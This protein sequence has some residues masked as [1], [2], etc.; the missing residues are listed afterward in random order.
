[1]RCCHGGRRCRSRGEHLARRAAESDPALGCLPKLRPSKIPWVMPSSRAS[2]PDILGAR[3]FWQEPP[4]RVS[5]LRIHNCGAESLGR[6]FPFASVAG[7]EPELG[8][9][10]PPRQLTPAP[11][12][13]QRWKGTPA[14]PR[15]SRGLPG[16]SIQP[17]TLPTGV[18]ASPAAGTSANAGAAQHMCLRKRLSPE[19]HSYS[20]W[21]QNAWETTAGLAGH[22]RTAATAPLPRHASGL[23]LEGCEAVAGTWGC[24]AVRCSPPGQCFLIRH[25]LV[26]SSEGQAAPSS[27]GAP[28]TSRT[29]VST[30]HLQP[31]VRP[32]WVQALHSLQG[33]GSHVS[34]HS[35]VPGCTVVLGGHCRKHWP[36]CK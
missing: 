31:Q 18:P 3:R 32:S 34:W 6:A 17:G 19:L 25:F 2:A 16:K 29:R 5:T 35:R 11:V 4:L 36:L 7:R 20:H 28:G 1:M 9:F 30:P 24:Q 26:S 8:S 33:P 10:V 21:L 23:A 27:R 14:G 15:R 12:P 22:H 13:A